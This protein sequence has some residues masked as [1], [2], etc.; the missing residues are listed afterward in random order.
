MPLLVTRLMHLTRKILVPVLLLLLLC[1]CA[2][3]AQSSYELSDANSKPQSSYTD[4]TGR[5]LQQGSGG[6]AQNSTALSSA[7]RC[8]P[9]FVQTCGCNHTGDGGI[10][11]SCQHQAFACTCTQCCQAANIASNYGDFVR[12]TDAP[13]CNTLDPKLPTGGVTNCTFSLPVPTTNTFR[14]QGIT[15]LG[16]GL[17]FAWNYKD[18]DDDP[19][20]HDRDVVGFHANFQGL[21]SALLKEDSGEEDY[22]TVAFEK[23]TPYGGYELYADDTQSI[24]SVNMTFANKLQSSN[25]VRSTLSS[26][27]VGLQINGTAKL[28][29]GASSAFWADQWYNATQ[30][31]PE[32]CVMLGH[33]CDGTAKLWRLCRLGGYGQA[34]ASVKVTLLHMPADKSNGIGIAMLVVGVVF[35][36]AYLKNDNGLGILFALAAVLQVINGDLHGFK[37]DDLNLASFIIIIVSLILTICYH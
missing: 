25:N 31:T 33:G 18:T 34:D 12:P 37:N 36:I 35:A 2:C 26:V 21:Y 24:T 4:E 9:N 23:H 3:V 19:S 27:P 30:G 11:D 32:R 8:Q 6:N 13:E 29:L 7:I 10:Q 16:C 5:R 28:P 14:Y 1:A 17:S 20:F 15:P 22:T